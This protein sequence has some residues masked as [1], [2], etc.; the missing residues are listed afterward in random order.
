[1]QN[2]EQTTQ[3]VVLAIDG[4]V[5]ARGHNHGMKKPALLVIDTPEC[6]SVAGSGECGSASRSEGPDR[7]NRTAMRGWAGG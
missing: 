6:N 3:A 2:D 4:V 7:A 1:M 5:A